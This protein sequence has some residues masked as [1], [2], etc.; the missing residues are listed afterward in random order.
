VQDVRSNAVADGARVAA[1]AADG[2]E[3]E[4]GPA[5]AGDGGHA[6]PED[7][8]INIGVKQTSCD[9]KYTYRKNLVHSFSEKSAPFSFFDHF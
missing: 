3:P 1:A 6:G 4:S 2:H 7:D 8:D 5:A 9:N